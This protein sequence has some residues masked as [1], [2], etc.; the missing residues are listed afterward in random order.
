M[1]TVSE[2][3]ISQAQANMQFV[4]ALAAAGGDYC[5]VQMPPEDLAKVTEI[6]FPDG[7]QLG[8]DLVSDYNLDQYP[9]TKMPNLRKLR[10]RDPETILPTG[11]FC[12]MESRQAEI[13]MPYS[14]LRSHMFRACYLKSVKLT[15]GGRM[16]EHDVAKAF[17]HCEA[18]RVELPEGLTKIQPYIFYYSRIR[19]SVGIPSTVQRICEDAFY[20][21][22]QKEVI[23]PEA[24]ATVGN[25]AFSSCTSLAELDISHVQS[26]GYRAF[27]GCRSLKEVE[28]N[29]ATVSEQAFFGSGLTFVRFG[30]NVTTISNRAFGQCYSLK[31]L[32]LPQN[33]TQV[34][35]NAFDRC[36]GLVTVRLRNQTAT[37]HQPF[38]VCQGL[39]TI[40]F[41][42]ALPTRADGERYISGLGLTSSQ[43][44]SADR[45]GR[46][47]WISSGACSSD[48]VRSAL[49]VGPAL[50][51]IGI[52]TQFQR[53]VL[54][55]EFGQEGMSLETADALTRALAQVGGAMDIVFA[56]ANRKPLK[57]ISDLSQVKAVL[58]R[59]R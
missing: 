51:A 56:D 13:E 17:Y 1:R 32:D 58:F 53:G 5:R 15:A 55:A 31:S 14:V 35:W 8:G 18:E 28:C 10:I 29:M 9:F 22:Y 39:K 19:N 26:M 33:V 38:T 59:P 16:G 44:G 36:K 50:A 3:D 40:Y 25:R 11:Y 45:N 48:A 24:C 43:I 21:S 34:G 52:E 37:L 27:Y 6:E 57:A 20:G 2:S 54:Y 4:Q 49:A 41:D 46:V 42:W 12:H 47:A 23:L 30:P 7:I